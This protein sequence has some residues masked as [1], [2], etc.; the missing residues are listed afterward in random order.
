MSS[1]VVI[2]VGT[3]AANGVR[4]AGS[5]YLG[6]TNACCAAGEV[7]G[8][9]ATTASSKSSTLSTSK[10]SKGTSKS[11]QKSGGD[12]FSN[13]IGGILNFSG[14]ALK[15]GGPFSFLF[16]AIPGLG[17]VMKGIGAVTSFFGGNKNA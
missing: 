11:T 15:G 6:D 3:Q 1:P 9:G 13:L 10:S 8:A 14:G 4:N 17:P 7:K 16:A 2:N 12:F 5:S